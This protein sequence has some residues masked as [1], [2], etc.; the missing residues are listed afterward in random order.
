MKLRINKHSFKK[1]CFFYCIFYTLTRAFLGSVLGSIPYIVYLGA[2]GICIVSYFTTYS[3]QKQ[4]L[5]KTPYYILY[6]IYMIY[7]FFNMIILQNSSKYALYE[8]LFYMLM[9]FAVCSIFNNFKIEHI[10]YFYEMV[11]MVVSIEAIWEFITGNLPFRMSEEAQAIRRACGLVGTPLTLGM[12]LACLT[13]IAFYLGKIRSPKHYLISLLNFIALLMTQSRGPLMGFVIAFLVL[14][15]FDSYRKTGKYVNSMLLL[16]IKCLGIGCILLIILYVFGKDNAFITTIL[17]R[18][19]TISEW[20]GADNSN[21]LRQKYWKIGLSY[22]E[23]YPIF[24]YGVSTSGTHSIT[25]INVESGVIKKLMETGIIGFSLYYVMFIGNV[26]ASLRKCIRRKGEYY[27]LAIAVII[28][29]FI[30]N[31]V[32]QIIESAAT[33][34]LFILF[35]TCLFMEGN[36]TMSENKEKL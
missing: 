35:F 31:I 15:Y 6:A 13:L 3:R 27:P 2:M 19:Q 23:K 7:I 32:L 16:M 24:G 25:H 26:I 36:G 29:I 34:L 30:E 20:S 11:G 28:A 17:K 8:Y 12:I 18:T 4:K 33:F 21:M 9:F 10:L 1:W 14:N 5:T 22:F